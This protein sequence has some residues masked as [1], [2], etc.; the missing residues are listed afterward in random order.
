MSKKQ[1]PT[2]ADTS[3]DSEDAVIRRLDAILGL[4]VQWQPAEGAKRSAEEQTIS[5]ARAGLRPVEIARITGRVENN[6]SRDI[7]NARK[8]G[9]L[10]KR[11]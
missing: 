10:R 1:A 9:R 4:L 7:S 6:I 8:A 11:K 5:L 3:T 2:V